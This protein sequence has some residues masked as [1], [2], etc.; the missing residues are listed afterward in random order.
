M[1][2]W[3]YHHGGEKKGPVEES[4]LIGLLKSG[5]LPSDALVW[6]EGME[7]WVEVSKSTDQAF[8]PF[9]P[10]PRRAGVL[11]IDFGTCNC[12]MAV[13]ENGKTVVIP[14]AEGARTTASV[15][16][17]AA[18][19]RWLVGG[20]AKRQAVTN[21]RNTIFSVKRL[22]GRKYTETC[23]AAK[24]LP[25]DIAKAPNDDAHVKIGARAYAPQEL[26]AIILCKLK[27]D[28]ETF[29]GSEVTQ[30]VITVP[31]AYTDSQR[32]SIKDAAKIAGL[33][34]LRIVNES[35]AACLAYGLDKKNNETVAIVH[36]GGGTFDVTILNIGDGVFEVMATTG[37]TH[38]GGDDIDN[39]I[40]DWLLN[41]AKTSNGIE[42]EGCPTSRQRLREAAES[43]KCNL[44]ETHKVDISIPF[45]GM[46]NTGPVHLTAIL[47]LE[48]LENL[49]APIFERMAEPVRNC[50]KDSGVSAVDHVVLAGAMTRMPGVQ[51]KIE[52]LF[53]RP[54]FKGVHPD[55]AVAIGAALQGGILLGSIKDAL[56]LDVTPASLGVE[57]K[58]GLITE[59]VA[60]NTTIPTMKSE[61]FSTTQ[62]NQASIVVRV[63]QGEYKR[64]AD[65]KFVGS[66]RLDGIPPAPCGVPQIQVTFKIDANGILRVSAKDLG[67]GKEQGI[68]GVMHSGLTDTEIAIAKDRIRAFSVAYCNARASR[69]SAPRATGTKH[70]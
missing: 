27:I 25:Y 4:V 3:Y 14:N 44:T 22:M 37:D 10:P 31:S 11:G 48:T 1:K 26:A 68:T 60:R 16:A 33:D 8:S 65:N 53:G 51:R 36:F 13:V 56:L 52:E 41:A 42:L 47:T 38:L 70:L 15:V 61:I 5:E 40:V 39:G 7:S 32:Q 43:A 45:I 62:D 21:P 34:A 29:L 69:H 28:A 55:E 23:D 35:T 46:T 2:H 6:S 12:C 18:D 50:L 58:G 9:R 64:A 20:P 24:W 19:G 49:A 66:F 30:A 67:T 59:M 17:L 54:P 57:G 63:F